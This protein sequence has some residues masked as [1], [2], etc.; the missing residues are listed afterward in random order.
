MLGK[1]YLKWVSIEGYRIT[2]A[3]TFWDLRR[4]SVE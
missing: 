4:I 3:A 1:K 2:M